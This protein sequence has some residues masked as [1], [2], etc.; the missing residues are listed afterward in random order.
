[1]IMMVFENVIV[2]VVAIIVTISIIV[3]IS[4]SIRS[5]SFYDH[6]YCDY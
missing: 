5:T 3:S 2:I 1:M 6:H 4:M